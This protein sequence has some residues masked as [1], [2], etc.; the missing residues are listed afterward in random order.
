MLFNKKR[1]PKTIADIN[2]KN[3][4]LTPELFQY[5]WRAVAQARK[6]EESY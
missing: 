4:K 6:E 2:L 1:K 3:K 5:Y